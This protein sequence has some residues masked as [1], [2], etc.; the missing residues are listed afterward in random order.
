VRR[1]GGLGALRRPAGI[2][3]FVLLLPCHGHHK[4]V[5]GTDD[6]LLYHLRNVVL[7]TGILNRLR[8]PY[9]FGDRARL[10]MLRSRYG[11][12]VVLCV[13]PR[14]LTQHAAGAAAVE[15]EEEEEGGEA[16]TTF[17]PIDAPCTQ[18]LR[19]GDP[20]HAQEQPHL[21]PPRLT[22]P[23]AS[24]PAWARA[25]ARWLADSVGRLR[26]VGPAWCAGGGAAAMSAEDRR[27]LLLAFYSHAAPLLPRMCRALGGAPC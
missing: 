18:C 8:F 11:K 17:A 1:G 9:D 5:D 12:R 19:H 3:G 14:A 20:L 22:G 7:R 4:L 2:L 27:A 10:L 15:E 24:H 6:T 25:L 13:E 16:G 23:S 26:G 21:L